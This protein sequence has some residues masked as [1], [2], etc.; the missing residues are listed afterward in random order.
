[1]AKNECHSIGCCIE[2]CSCMKLFFSV[3]MPHVFS[4]AETRAMTYHHSTTDDRFCFKITKISLKPRQISQYGFELGRETIR[5]R[6]PEESPKTVWL[7]ELMALI[8][9]TSFKPF[10]WRLGFMLEKRRV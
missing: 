5:S 6:K 7:Q 8:C 3:L 2:R 10:S 9:F 1:L 4:A